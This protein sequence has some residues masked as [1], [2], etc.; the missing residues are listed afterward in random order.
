MYL[1]IYIIYDNK[2]PPIR[3]GGNFIK[4]NLALTNLS[5]Y[6]PIAAFLDKNYWFLLNMGTLVPCIIYALPKAFLIKMIPLH[7]FLPYCTNYQ[8]VLDWFNVIGQKQKCIFLHFVN[9]IWMMSRLIRKNS[10]I[11]YIQ[12]GNCFN[13]PF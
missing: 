10:I 9:K 4:P 6:F 11:I 2:I 8:F 12:K 3:Y 13:V 1:Y 5:L 7:L